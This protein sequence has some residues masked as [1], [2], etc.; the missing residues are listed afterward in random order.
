[1]NKVLVH[2]VGSTVARLIGTCS[3]RASAS[4]RLSQSCLAAHQHSIIIATYFYQFLIFGPVHKGA[5][6]K[7]VEVMMSVSRPKLGKV[8]AFLLLIL[9]NSEHVLGEILSHWRK[10]EPAEWPSTL[11]T[12][13]YA[14]HEQPV[15][16]QCMTPRYPSSPPLN[17]TLHN[18]AATRHRL[19]P[20]RAAFVS[21]QPFNACRLLT[22]HISSTPPCVAGSGVQY[23]RFFC[24][25][26]HTDYIDTNTDLPLLEQGLRLASIYL[27]GSSRLYRAQSTYASAKWQWS[28]TRPGAIHGGG[29]REGVS[30]TLD[31]TPYWDPQDPSDRIVA[32]S[33]CCTMYD[34]EP[35]T[36]VLRTAGGALVGNDW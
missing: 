23:S 10:Y 29:T 8:P 33:T 11:H 12:S 31:M 24:G 7:T 1:M 14:A 25:N 5:K 19:L 2:N 28:S 17:K 15:S 9:A 22:Q 35:L 4:L 27:E 34:N 6:L 21:P 3:L 30:T 20:F 32:V 16:G 13:V 36:I 18:V 26:P